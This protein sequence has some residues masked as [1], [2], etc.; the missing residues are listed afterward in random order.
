MASQS[1]K[2]SPKIPGISPSSH[3]KFKARKQANLLLERLK[4]NR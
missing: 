1:P 4:K 2:K 3:Q